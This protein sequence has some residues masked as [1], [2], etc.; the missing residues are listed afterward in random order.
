MGMSSTSTKKTD[1]EIQ[2]ELEDARKVTLTSATGLGSGKQ[3]IGTNGVNSYGDVGV[4]N[5]YVVRSDPRKG[6]QEYIDIGGEKAYWDDEAGGWAGSGYDGAGGN[7][8]GAMFNTFNS[9]VQQ[10]QASS[11]GG[12]G[13]GGGGGNK[14]PKDW[15]DN[16][17]KTIHPGSVGSSPG[18]ETSGIVDTT[19]MDNFMGSMAA[20]PGAVVNPNVDPNNWMYQVNPEHQIARNVG[21]YKNPAIDDWLKNS[22]KGLLSA[23]GGMV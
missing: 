15:R 1:A 2:K 18:L 3:T 12:G 7:Q 8:R 21:V 11:G 5:E 9:P 6:G 20:T 22:Q 10:A 23:S 13:G 14:P 16:I 17:D 19:G 4:G